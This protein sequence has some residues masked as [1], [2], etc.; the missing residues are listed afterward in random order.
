M[1]IQL[2]SVIEDIKK[3]FKLILDKREEP[4][5]LAEILSDL[6]QAVIVALSKNIDVY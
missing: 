6:D 4:P 1:A 2:E 3:E 5:D